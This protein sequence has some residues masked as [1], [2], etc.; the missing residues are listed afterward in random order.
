MLRDDCRGHR[1]QKVR[2]QCLLFL[3]FLC[4]RCGDRDEDL[5]DL[6]CGDGDRERFDFRGDRDF[7]LHERQR[8]RLN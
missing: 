6:C 5:Q 8:E 3:V 1:V 7:V 2:V 4:E